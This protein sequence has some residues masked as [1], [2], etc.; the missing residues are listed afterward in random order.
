MKRYINLEDISDGKLYTSEDLV[1]AGCHDCRDCHL[2][3][4]GMGKSVIL[5]P[6]DVHRMCAGLHV[7]FETLV[8]TYIELSFVDGIILPN[9]IM[10]PKT[11]SCNFLNAD[12]RCDIHDFRPGFCRLFPLGRIYEDGGFKYFLQT[13]ECPM[14]AKTKVRIRQW[15][16]ED[17]ITVYEAFV[18]QWHDTLHY[19][20]NIIQSL[21]DDNRQL[22]CTSILKFFYMTPYGNQFYDIFTRRA[23]KFLTV[24]EQ[25]K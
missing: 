17:N 9:L 11:D 8:G 4:T 5:D 24:L 3:C 16:G 12:G 18:N 20:Q 15:L 22:L 7:P 13:K 23:E 2:C 1:K 25:F 10:N 14:P 6:L 19:C 21:D